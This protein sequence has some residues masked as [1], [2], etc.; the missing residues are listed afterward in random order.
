[1]RFDVND[2]LEDLIEDTKGSDV[3]PNEV[4]EELLG[5]E[6]LE[7]EIEDFEDEEEIEEEDEDDDEEIV[8]DEGDEEFS[9]D[10]PVKPTK[11]QK[12]EYAWAEMR[13]DNKQKQLE[14][15]RLNQIAVG[16]G[17]KNHSEM[18]DKL[19]EDRLIKEA[20]AKGQDP[21]VFKKM[22]SMEN[23]IE[24]LKKERRAEIERERALKFLNNVDNFIEK[25]SLSENE[26]KELIEK[27]DEDGF[28]V[29]DLSKIKNTDALFSSYV[30]GTLSERERQAQLEKEAK[31][32]R[33]EED[34]FTG[35][36]A[37]AELTLEELMNATVSRARTKKY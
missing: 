33:L 17:F 19:E 15:D 36:G 6:E 37:D 7:E 4:L 20:K 35:T 1:M 28:T 24:T 18:L 32:K 29:D 13:K 30:K 10:E 16:Y 14:L 31:R 23:E 8:Y 25:N 22:H 12:A 5:E 9:F 34:K 3:N 26:K 11:E 21:E 2:I 27:L